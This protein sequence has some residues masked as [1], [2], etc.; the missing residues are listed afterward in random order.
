MV[1]KS[2]RLLQP[3]IN[4]YKSSIDKST[5]SPQLDKSDKFVKSPEYSSLAGDALHSV[6]KQTSESVT[7]VKQPREKII[8]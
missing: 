6:H 1:A 5:K 3:H 2:K 8:T 4:K 7:R